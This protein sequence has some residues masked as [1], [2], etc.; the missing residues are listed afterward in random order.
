MFYDPEPE[1]AED[2]PQRVPGANLPSM[3]EIRARW[4]ARREDDAAAAEDA[5]WD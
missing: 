1:V 4:K 5:T 2:L 3:A